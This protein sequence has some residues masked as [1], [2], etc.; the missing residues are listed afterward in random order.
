METTNRRGPALAVNA[1]ALARVGTA[2]AD[3]NRRRLLLALL[4]A[5]AYPS[6]LAET[7]GMTRGNVSNHL[8]CLRGCGL[9]RTVPVGRRVRYELADPK[10]AHA[11]ADLAALVLLVDPADTAEDICGPEDYACGA[12]EPRDG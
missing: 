9:V 11:L 6:D 7:L 12:G 3:E 2:L 5:P 4:E 1:E 8:S 10:L